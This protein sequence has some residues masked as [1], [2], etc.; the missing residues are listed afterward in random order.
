MAQGS[1]G[2]GGY[3]VTFSVVDQATG[4]IDAIQRRIRQLREPIDRMRRDTQ[5][6]INPQGLRKVSDA[7]GDIGRQAAT[8]F[9]SLSRLVPVMGAIGGVAS[10]AGLAGLGRQWASFATQLKRDSDFIRGSTPQALQQLQRAFTLVGGSAEQV[11]GTLKDLTNTAAAAFRGDA[12][13]AT[14]FREAKISLEDFNGQLRPSTELLPEV[15]TYI[16]SLKDPTDRLTAANGFGSAALRDMVQQLEAARR[17]GEN[18][19]DTYRRVNEQAAKYPP[20]TDKQIAAMQRHKEAMASLGVSVDA[21]G[22]RVG[23]NMASAF[24]PFVVALDKFASDP[25]TVK[26]VDDLTTAFGELLEGLDWDYV[27]GFLRDTVVEITKL[28]QLVK[29]AVKWI[30]SF[31]EDWAKFWGG[32]ARAPTPSTSPE[33]VVAELAGGSAAWQAQKAQLDAKAA[34]SGGGG[35]VGRWIGGLFGGGGGETATASGEGSRGA[36]VPTAPANEN[37]P[38]GGGNPSAKLS[39][40]AR[41]LLDT[42]AGSESNIKGKDPYTLLYGGTNV[43]LEPGARSPGIPIRS[44]PNKGLTSSAYGRYQFINPTWFDLVHGID[45][46]S[47]EKTK[48]GLIDKMPELR[49]DFLK[50]TPRAQDIAAWEKAKERYRAGGGGNLEDD[51]RRGKLHPGGQAQLGEEWTSLPG[52]IEPNPATASFG[53]RLGGN[54]KRQRAMELAQGAPAEVTG[55]PPVNGAVDV[56]ITH[57]NP[58][59]GA[60]VTASATGDATVGAPRTEQQQL[61]NVG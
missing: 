60:T 35:V 38:P 48:K 56:T 11:T 57:K 34:A 5:D 44:G 8:A 53:G 14:W 55:G 43:N 61:A 42:I 31:K 12:N 50:R 2:R 59:P 21:L 24:T 37:M 39:A 26:A 30:R 51:L 1:Q 46:K 27:L 58:P 18:L 49:E 47:G 32:E 41:G 4:P 6:F 7:F 40:E 22:Q 25:A 16:S 52:G 54:I 20:L 19:A 10:L 36:T 13:A 17:P 9:S 3:A 29:D 45:P 23:T 33:D 15:L 28:I